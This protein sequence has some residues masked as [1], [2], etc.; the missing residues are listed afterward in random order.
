MAL[1]P[2]TEMSLAK[3]RAGEA[4]NYEHEHCCGKC[5]REYQCPDRFIMPECRTSPTWCSPCALGLKPGDEEYKA[6]WEA[7]GLEGTRG[8]PGNYEAVPAA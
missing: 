5:L 8:T 7:H 3:R 6:W 4:P 2:Y 1:N